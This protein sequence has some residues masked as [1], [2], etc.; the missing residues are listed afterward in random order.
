MTSLVVRKGIQSTCL[1]RSENSAMP[2]LMPSW[3]RSVNTLVCV[4]CVCQ[5]RI[6]SRNTK[7]RI[8]LTSSSSWGMPVS[9]APDGVTGS[10]VRP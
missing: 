5:G 6:W 4:S 8:S 9:R 3:T 10:G 2:A 7:A 1:T